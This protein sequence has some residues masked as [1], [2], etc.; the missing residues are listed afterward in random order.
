MKFKLWVISFSALF[1]V[2]CAKPET[3]LLEE[4]YKIKEGT[5]RGTFYRTIIWQP[6]TY[7]AVTISFTSNTWEGTSEF[8]YYPA[9]CHGTYALQDS[10]V[11]FVNECVWP[12]H[13]DWTLILSGI[14]NFRIEDDTINFVKI[15]GIDSANFVYKD[16]YRLT[17]QE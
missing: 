6:I 7:S 15:H 9:L 17:F 3:E 16:V 13:F 5:Y 14:Y 1:I 8:A 12:A 2:G 11:T 4:T 10:A